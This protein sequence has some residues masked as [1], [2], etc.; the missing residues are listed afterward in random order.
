MQVGDIISW[1]RTFTEDDVRRFS[2]VSGDAGVHHIMCDRM[3]W[4]A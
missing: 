1:Q 4:V 3:P 2:Y